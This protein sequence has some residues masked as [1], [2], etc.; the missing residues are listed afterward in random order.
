MLLKKMTLTNFR[1]FKGEHE[2]VFSTDTEKNVTLVMAENGAG[3]TTLAQAFQWGLYSKTE[4]FKNKSVLN[5]IVEKEMMLNSEASVSVKLELE[6]NNVDYTIIRKQIYKKDINGNVKSDNPILEIYTKKE[7]GQ[8][9]VNNP[10]KN[11]S[12]ISNILP[13][14]LSKYFFFDGERIEKMAGEVNSGRS[15]EF[16]SAVQ[17]ILGL[18]ALTKAIEHLNPNQKNSVIGRYN[19]QMDAA[20]DQKTR[21]LRDTIYSSTDKIEANNQRIDKIDEEITFYQAEIEKAKAEILSFADTEKMQ[22]E[23]NR[24]NASLRQEN[25]TKNNSISLLM[26]NFTKQTYSYFS[27]HLIQEALVELKNTDNIDKGIPSVR[28]ETIKF[29][30]NRKKC[31]CGSDLSD[32]R[33]EAVQNLTELLKYIPPQ[34]VGTA[35]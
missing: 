32:P 22:Q 2:I 33:S 7:D 34:S 12:T 35:I 8:T 23:L 4:G 18:T 29:L 19:A 10:Y 30:M 11:V 20:G 9:V 27:R 1:P 3:K 21:E 24:L 13:E 16:K 31:L 15:D 28:A 5:S 26:S 14:S 17:N 25:L 6:H